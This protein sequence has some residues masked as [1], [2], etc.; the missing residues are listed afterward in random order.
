VLDEAFFLPY[1]A[2]SV[3]ISAFLTLRY[4]Y[5]QVMYPEWTMMV[6]LWAW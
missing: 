4:Q 3:K 1:G 2:G 5:F 6:S